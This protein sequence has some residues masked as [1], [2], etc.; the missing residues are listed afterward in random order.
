MQGNL[1]KSL[2]LDQEKLSEEEIYLIWDSTDSRINVNCSDILQGRLSIFYICG[3]VSTMIFLYSANLI[4]C[5]STII[6]KNF[7]IQWVSEYGMVEN[8][9]QIT[10]EYKQTDCWYVEML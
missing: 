3:F 6:L 2:L 1:L 10:E 8:I 5:L 4:L 9:K 7:N